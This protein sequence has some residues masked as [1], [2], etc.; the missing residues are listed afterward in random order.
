MYVMAV[1]CMEREGAAF[2]RSFV[3]APL[4]RYEMAERKA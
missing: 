3:S 4:L 2:V 1:A